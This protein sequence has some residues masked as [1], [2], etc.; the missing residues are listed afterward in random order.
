MPVPCTSFC[1][2]DYL[3]HGPSPTSQLPSRPLSAPGRFCHGN[4][5]LTQRRAK[6]TCN[7]WSPFDFLFLG[8]G[9]E[10]SK[11]VPHWESIQVPPCKESAKLPPI[12]DPP[13]GASRAKYFLIFIL[14]FVHNTT[15]IIRIWRWIYRSEIL[16][17][18]RAHWRTNK[19]TRT[20]EILLMRQ[21]LCCRCRAVPWNC[22]LSSTSSSS[23][24]NC[25]DL[26]D[27]RRQR[28]N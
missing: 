6:R 27:S 22:E 17:A 1:L 11:G 20:P 7:F 12:L 4:V 13:R 10:K 19:T 24:L 16:L 28:S 14:I 23:L 15:F 18:T 3:G 21:S 2:L 25:E 26:G 9:K 5:L 8:T